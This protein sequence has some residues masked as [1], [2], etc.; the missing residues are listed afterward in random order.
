MSLQKLSYTQIKGYPVTVDSF[1][2]VGDGTTDD[3]VA[4]QAA[5]DAAIAAKKDLFIQSGTYKIT[6]TLN[7]T[8][9]SI[10]I[11]GAGRYETKINSYAVGSAIKFAGWGGVL[12][13]LG[14][15]TQNSTGS[16]I[17]AG[18]VSRNCAISNVYIQAY[19]VYDPTNTGAGIYLNAGVGFSGGIEIRTTYCLGFKYGVKMVGTNLAT[20]TWTT[21]SMFNLWIASSTTI[22]N[23]VGIY[24]DA[25]TN[26][27]GTRLDGGTI[28][29][30]VTGIK[31][32]DNS[33]GGTF[34]TDME[35]NTAD[36]VVGNAFLGSITS[37]FNV[38]NY[39]IARN[40]P[41]GAIWNQYELIGGGSPKQENYYAP[42]YQ[43]YNG[44]G[45]LQT[46]KWYRS[47]GSIIDGTATEAH[48]LKFAVGL[49]ANGTYGINSNPSG[50]YL[51]LD[52][53][54]IHWDAISP[55]AEAGSQIVAWVQGSVCYNSAATVGQ[56]KGWICTVSGT[57]GTWVSMGNL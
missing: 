45:D 41:A 51:Q 56:P 28:E 13:N 53:R 36:Y 50:H 7:V 4:L 48:A 9:T 2:A 10:K 8:S 29:G 46:I 25:L 3:T 55:Q 32:E 37:A 6:N 24:M 43:V 35:G 16:G 31:V 27:I 39:S 22:A 33:Y 11:Y 40:G 49:G 47:A 15:Y 21:V 19:N 23:S 20:D 52:D 34:N 1:G 42:Q 17:E 14:I 44:S 12:D 18:T 26:G 38:P 30:C 57:P 5:I 54:T